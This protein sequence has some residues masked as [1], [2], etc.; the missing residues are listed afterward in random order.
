MYAT[1]PMSHLF[2]GIHEQSYIAH[3]IG[4]AACMGW[5]KEMC[6]N[7]RSQPGCPADETAGVQSVNSNTSL[8][9]VLIAI[10]I[11][12]GLLQKNI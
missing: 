12:I 9:Y 3:A 1:G 8:T 11:I 2:T 6:Q 5:N 4:Y 7:P 10:S